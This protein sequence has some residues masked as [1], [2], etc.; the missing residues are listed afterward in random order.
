MRQTIELI[1]KLREDISQYRR[2][3][4]FQKGWQWEI[5]SPEVKWPRYGAS[6]KAI[7]LT[8]TCSRRSPTQSSLY[9]SLFLVLSKSVNIYGVNL[10]RTS[11]R[12]NYK[13][14]NQEYDEVFRCI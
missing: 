5:C 9:A 13:L 4:T 6:C 3:W 12:S 10:K 2:V 7:S 14:H 1:P 8:P 11:G